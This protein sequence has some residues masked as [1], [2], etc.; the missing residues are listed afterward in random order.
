[1]ESS[2]SLMEG[3]QDISKIRVRNR[4]KPSTIGQGGTDLLGRS[5]LRLGSVADSKHE[6]TRVIQ[7]QSQGES[8]FSNRVNDAHQELDHRNKAYSKEL[9]QISGLNRPCD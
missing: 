3:H 5:M 9:V 4:W 8:R 2:Y 1:M 7:K 6:Q